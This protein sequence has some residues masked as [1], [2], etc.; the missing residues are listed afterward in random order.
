MQSRYPS[1][2]CDH[3]LI[4][5]HRGFFM[6]RSPAVCL[7][8][9]VKGPGK[10]KECRK[11]Y[12]AKYH[13]DNSDKILSR[14]AQ[15]RKDRPDRYVES[16]AKYRAKK[17]DLSGIVSTNIAEKLMILQKG[18]CACCGEKLMGGFHIDHIIPLSKGGR[19]EDC[20]LQLLTAGCNLRKSSKDP[21]KFMQE[22]G[23]LI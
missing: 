11:I 9:H 20:N 8:G 21:I 6:G 17:K 16:S 12:N 19:H 13:E 14:K 1:W 22:R 18:R 7:K 5:D 2:G 15:Y 23:F 10:C 3:H 4:L